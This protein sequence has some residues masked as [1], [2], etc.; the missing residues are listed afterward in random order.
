MGETKFIE[1]TEEEF[2]KLFTGLKRSPTGKH[3]H[4]EQNTNF[5]EQN[6]H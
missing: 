4:E 6:S 1:F 5:E 3:H 2:I